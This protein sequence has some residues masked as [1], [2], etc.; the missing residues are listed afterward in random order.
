MKNA[1]DSDELEAVMTEMADGD[2]V[3]LEKVR[4]WAQR[5]RAKAAA[6]DNRAAADPIIAAD[7]PAPIVEQ[8][9]P[10][11]PP[12]PAAQTAPPPAPAP[13]PKPKERYGEEPWRPYVSESGI[14]T[15]PR[16]AESWSPRR[17]W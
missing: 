10:A 6:A 15:A 3:A 13:S 12:A 8:Q 5:R 16:S 11:P 1:D 4:L 7:Q 14:S 17:G 2:P 9:T